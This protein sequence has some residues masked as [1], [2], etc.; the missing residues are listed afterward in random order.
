MTVAEDERRTGDEPRTGLRFTGTSTA[1]LAALVV[2][3]VL[4]A[5]L[6][7]LLA[8]PLVAMDRAV[9]AGVNGWVAARPQVVAVLEAITPLGAELTGAVVLV[10][11][12]VALLVRG[13][14][15]LA[16]Y[17]AA[18]GVGGAVL[19]PVVKALVGRLRPL[20]DAPVATAPGP[21]FPSGHTLTVTVWV[22]VVLLVLLPAVPARAR[23]A[24]VAAGVTVVVLVGLTRIGLGV[25]F[26]TDVVAGW[27]LGAAW[28]LVTATAF[29][30]ALHVRGGPGLD[31]AA[32]EDLAP[33]PDHRTPDVSPWVR[34]TQLLIVA[35]VLTGIVI[36]AGLVVTRSVLSEA[37]VAAD[38]AVLNWFVDN[39]TPA[40]DALS[41]PVGELGNT[42]VVITLGIVAAVVGLA[43]ARRWRAAILMAL[44]LIGELLLFMVAAG[45]TGRTRPPVPHLDAQLPPT[46]S[47]PSGHTTAALCLYGGVAVLV[48]AA[49]QAWWRWLVVAVAVAV[50]VAVALTRLYRGAHH[51]SD[52]L[53]SVLLG[54]PWL[55]ACSTA[56]GLL[57]SSAP[58]RAPWRPHRSA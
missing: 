33:A 48:C 36:G 8:G 58:A 45:V 9:A 19:G 16:L 43:V 30:S 38:L 51:P 52:V 47:F 26:V 55:I 11:L 25:H 41:L 20:V 42:T 2:G 3:G 49:T 31:P 5:G 17:V 18:A 39:R 7:A 14:R 40:L 37:I 50:V 21:S 6:I 34:A 46:S 32:A 29:R 1:G 56:L 23:R 15:G 22:G 27:L 57:G 10:T 4:L 35:V 24:V 44:V 13:R 53:G 12:A 54:V 28:L